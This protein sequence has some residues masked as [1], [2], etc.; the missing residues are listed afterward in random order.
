MFARTLKFYNMFVFLY[1]R[2]GRLPGV[3]QLTRVR[4][5]SRLRPLPED[6]PGRAA[7]RE[8]SVGREARL[9]R[10]QAEAQAEG[11]VSTCC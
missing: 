9:Y 11:S 1:R 3:H 10:A 8:T 4:L 6:I 7:G 2:V 5:C